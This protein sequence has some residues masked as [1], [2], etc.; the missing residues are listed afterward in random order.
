MLVRVFRIATAVH[1]LLLATLGA[2]FSA[3]VWRIADA[4]FPEP[5]IVVLVPP[6]VASNDV[7]ENNS[8]QPNSV[9]NGR[10]NHWNGSRS[11]L[12]RWPGS[13][14]PQADSCSISASNVWTAL[15]E[16]QA[17][18]AP[19]DPIL[20]VPMRYTVPLARLLNRNVGWQEIGF[21]LFGGV[22]SLIVWSFFGGG[23]V[24]IAAVHLARQERVGLVDALNYGRSN[25]AAYVAAPLMPLAGIATIAIPM[26]PLGWL[27]L[28]DFG[29]MISGIVW[30]LVL[31][32]AILM[33]IGAIGLL[34]GWPLMWG[35]IGVDGSDSFDAISRAYAYT[36]Q[37]PLEYL[38]YVLVTIAL[39]TLGWLLVWG[40]SEA[41][42]SMAFWG[43]SWGAGSDRVNVVIS[44]ASQNTDMPTSVTNVADDS[45][46][47]QLTVMFRLGANLIV[48]AVGLV[49]S[50]ATGFGYSFFWCAAVGVYLLLRL[51]ADSTEL[52]DVYDDPN[53]EFLYG[54]P[55]LEQDDQG[56]PGVVDEST[57]DGPANGGGD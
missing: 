32:A 21:S 29:V 48:L 10:K 38:F 5:E 35:A 22:S 11:A 49:R 53:A 41:V 56:V 17:A 31:I 51:S 23:I 33:S 7:S 52:D 45:V 19:L 18:V 37:R 28:T 12:T 43:T 34:F 20:G 57:K 36:F 13:R 27:M 15:V 54:L 30:I 42:V 4:I 16:R 9:G 47:K 1:V 26:V 25:L 24:R 6:E 55:D 2:L 44:Y 14:C 46:K 8:S 50:V 40:F 39:G 3:G